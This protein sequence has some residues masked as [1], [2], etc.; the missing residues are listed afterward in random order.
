LIRKF[1]AAFSENRWLRHNFPIKIPRLRDSVSLTLT[2]K[3]RLHR[4]GALSL[5][6]AANNLWAVVGRRAVKNT[7]TMQ[8]TTAFWV[9]RAEIQPVE[10]RMGDRSGAHGA[11]LQRDPNRH[12]LQ[13]FSF[14]RVTRDLNR[15]EFGVC[16]GVGSGATFIS[17]GGDD[18]LRFEI[19]DYRANRRFAALGG[20][21]GLLERSGHMTAK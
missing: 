4:S 20:G 19:D 16:A 18:R 9:A 2:A 3:K 5:H 17:S 6:D 14:Y 11:R 21:P 1:E 10:T 13:A 12:S 15:D 8:N 7:W